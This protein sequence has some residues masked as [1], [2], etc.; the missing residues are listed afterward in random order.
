[1]DGRKLCT[2][3]RYDAENSGIS[4]T[5]LYFV[6][7][8]RNI[9]KSCCFEMFYLLMLSEMSSGNYWKQTDMTQVSAMLV[10]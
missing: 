8:K 1:M 9:N 2:A 4:K 5:N 3:D 6:F 10:L 7:L